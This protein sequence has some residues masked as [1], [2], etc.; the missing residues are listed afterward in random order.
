MKKYIH[1]VSLLLAVMLL[2]MSLASCDWGA[3]PVP[4]D[5][6]SSSAKQS[7]TPHK[8]G[9]DDAAIYG[10]KIGMTPE[11]VKKILG[12]PQSEELI[13]ND[14]FI[15]GAYIRMDYGKYEVSFYDLSE[16]SD[17]TLGSIL[18]NSGHVEF[19]G[20]LRPGCSKDEVLAAFTHE[21]NPEPLYFEGVEE[22]CG[23]YIYGSTNSSWF[24]EEK[25]TGEIQYA[26]IN[27]YGEE[28]THYYTME[29]Y[30]YPPLNWNADKS[31]YTGEYYSM[32]FYVDSEENLVTDI[33][34][35]HE[36]AQ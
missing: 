4:G 18:S 7:F 21:E 28:E 35:S 17:Y 36:L 15:Y 33:R 13:T 2:T 34:V 5:G 26:Y 19:A 22:S 27:R 23:D 10:A 1:V 32:V 6:T 16:G 9:V 20:G 29:Y 11:H 14:N 24:I 25:P 12:E 3:H 30:Y 8:F 31:A